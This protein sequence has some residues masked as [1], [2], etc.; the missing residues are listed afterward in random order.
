M[1][2]KHHG[3]PITRDVGVWN[4]G[5]RLWDIDS[6]SRGGGGV[7]GRHV[8][9][10]D[11]TRGY[12]LRDMDYGTRTGGGGKGGGWGGGVG[13]RH[14]SRH[15]PGARTQDDRDTGLSLSFSLSLSI[16]LP[17]PVPHL[18]PIRIWRVVV[19]ASVSKRASMLPKDWMSSQRLQD[20]REKK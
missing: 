17:S 12:G 14:T 4:M 1:D 10:V 7:T 9:D 3:L 8:R 2:D 16:S 13:G 11:W 6:R 5:H 20:W 19:L 15:V 18:R